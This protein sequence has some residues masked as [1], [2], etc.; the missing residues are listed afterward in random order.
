MK[1]TL[2]TISPLMLIVCMPCQHKKPLYKPF[3]WFWLI[4]LI[5][6][7][8]CNKSIWHT[9]TTWRMPIWATSDLIHCGEL[10]TMFPLKS[11]SSCFLCAHPACP[12]IHH[13]CSRKMISYSIGGG[14]TSMHVPSFLLLQMYI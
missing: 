4:I 2:P 7:C 14:R 8:L 9:A 5:V 11:F 1:A 13:L 6:T 12:T 10:S 3:C